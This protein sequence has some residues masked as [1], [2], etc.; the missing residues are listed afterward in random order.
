MISNL[1]TLL[2]Y[3]A[4]FLLVFWSPVIEDSD[5]KSH[6]DVTKYT[7]P[8]TRVLIK[9][10]KQGNRKKKKTQEKGHVKMRTVNEIT[11]DHKTLEETRKDS[12]PQL[13]EEV[14]PCCHLDFRF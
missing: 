12:S 5:F 1:L 10:T 13:S 6:W 9:V 3:S 4:W 11:R 8:M 7:H 2:I 14:W